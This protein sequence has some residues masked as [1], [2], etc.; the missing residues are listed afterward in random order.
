M[1]ACSTTAFAIQG[2]AGR[3]FAVRFEPH[4]RG[5]A[6]GSL[7]LVPPFAEEMNKSRRML[8]LLARRAAADGWRVLHVDPY[9]T[10]DSEGDFADAR[11]EIWRDDL[12]AC[13]TALRN[14][15]PGPLVLCAVR[16]GALLALEALQRIDAD[17]AQLVLWQPVLSGKLATT[18]FLRLKLAS[19]AMGG[20]SGGSVDALRRT[21]EAGRVLEVAGYPLA[22]E[23]VRAIDARTF[24]ASVPDRCPPVRWFDVASSASMSPSPATA[25]ALAALQTRGVGVTHATC[26]GPPFWA[27]A[28]IA[29]A[30]GLVDATVNALPGP[31]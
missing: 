9:G 4:V 17:V 31:A 24:A 2:Q 18:Q 6:R 22:A 11:W 14:E 26:E 10:G 15:H 27:T 3:L 25:A 16:L 12:A 8:T 29:V 1:A 21:L 7:L 20:G 5:S 23:L 19:E 13:G 30:P 28:E